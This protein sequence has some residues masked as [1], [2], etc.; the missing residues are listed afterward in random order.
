MSEL[1]A[2]VETVIELAMPR[3]DGSGASPL[4]VHARFLASTNPPEVN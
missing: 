4:V 2:G 1:W 3:Y